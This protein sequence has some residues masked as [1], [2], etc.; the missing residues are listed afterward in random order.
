VLL[1][2]LADRRELGVAGAREEHVDPA[3]LALHGVIEAVDVGEISG[4]ALDAGDVPAD[5]ANG[6]VELLLA[7]PRDEDVRP[8]VDE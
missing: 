1:R 4:V 8:L 5:R 7:P 2:H 3:L 6:V